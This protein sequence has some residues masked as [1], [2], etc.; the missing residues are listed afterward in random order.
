MVLI[1]FSP[2]PLRCCFMSWLHEQAHEILTRYWGVA[3]GA[4]KAFIGWIIV[5]ALFICFPP[6]LW[7][8]TTLRWNAT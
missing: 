3:V 2:L 5:S 8:H 7:L 6:L 4:A 1:G